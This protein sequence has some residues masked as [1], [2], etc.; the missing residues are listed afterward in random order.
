VCVWA[1]A[2]LEDCSWALRVDDKCLKAAVLRGRAHVGLKQYHSAIECYNRAKKIDATKE[3]LVN[4]YIDRARIKEKAERDECDAEQTSDQTGLVSLLDRLNQPAQPIIYYVGALEAIR[5]ALSEPLAK[6]LFRSSGGFELAESHYEISRCLSSKPS[7]LSRSDVQLSALY[8]VVVREAC[9]DN[10][11]NQCQVL[12]MKY[13]PQQLVTFIECLADVPGCHHL[14]SASV[15]LL[16]C[17]SQTARN[18]SEIVQR[19]DAVRLMTAAFMLAQCVDRRVN[20]VSMNMQRLICNLA[21]SQTLCRQLHDDFDQSVLGSFNSLLQS[22][23]ASACS[24]Q[25]TLTVKTMV[26]LCGDEYLRRHLSAN[27]CT[28]SSCITALSRLVIQQSDHQLTSTLVSLLANMALNTTSAVDKHDLVQLSGTCTDLLTQ[29]SAS[30]CAELVDRCY[31][32]LS[33]VLRVSSESVQAA[34]DKQFITAA[35]RDL[36]HH[37]DEGCDNEM[38]MSHCLAALTACTLHSEVGRQQL[39]DMKPSIIALLVTLLITHQSDHDDSL[40]GNV[41]LCLSHCVQQSSAV[42]QLTTAARNTDLIMIL[43]LLARDHAMPTV[44]HNCAI[45]IAKLV[46]QHEPF[47][48]RLRQL[49]GLEI[50]HTVLRHVQH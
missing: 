29:F 13:L 27:Q 24:S 17:L 21:M 31:L 23:S 28:W 46:Q 48:D 1:Q 34:V 25:L 33:R 9:I 43:L 18:R 5:Q 11:V 41:A 37:R 35:S 38:M 32:L 16:L 49:H 40:I 19:C 39:V 36:R 30:D 3:S 42:Q 14:A 22:S 12:A 6:T 2:A 10:D 45:L 20:E 15:D 26:N 7:S 47:L 44:Q 8:V 50:L 4:E